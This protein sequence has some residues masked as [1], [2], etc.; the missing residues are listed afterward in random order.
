MK[1]YQ[2]TIDGGE[3]RVDETGEI[4]KQYRAEYR[5]KKMPSFVYV[6]FYEAST[7]NDVIQ[8]VK[9]S[10]K[11]SKTLADFGDITSIQIIENDTNK[12]VKE[13]KRIKS[14]KL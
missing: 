11:S 10:L 2:Q 4:Y 9:E 1:Y 3:V 14:L 7:V 12:L 5:A 6:L 8:Q 13:F